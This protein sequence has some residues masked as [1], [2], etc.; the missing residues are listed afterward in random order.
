[1][2]EQTSREELL[3]NGDI[4]WENPRAALLKMRKVI[5]KEIR[6][7]NA[8]EKRRRMFREGGG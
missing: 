5:G 2:G 7:E 6:E 1:M 4:A 8:R 3:V